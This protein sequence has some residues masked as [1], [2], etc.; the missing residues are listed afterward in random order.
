ML[1]DAHTHTRIRSV[2]NHRLN[3]SSFKTDFLVEYGI[4]ITLQCLPICQSLVPCFA[5]RSTFT[6][7]DIFKSHF[8]RSNHPTTCTHFDR[9][10]TKGKTSLHC[11]IADGRTCIF[12]E[13]TGST[14]G[15]HLGHHIQ[16]YIFCSHPFAQFTV[17][18]DTHC[19][20]SWLKNTLRSQYH[21]HFTCSDAES[22]CSHRTMS[23][24]VRVTADNRHSRQSQTTFGTY[25]MDNSIL[26]MHHTVVCQTKILRILSQ[27]VDLR[28]R[29]RIL[30]LLILI[31]CR[32]VMVGHTKY[33]FRT[34]HSDSTFTQSGKS[35][36][37]SHFMTI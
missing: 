31:V 17:Y 12:Y 13:V 21:F 3:I 2:S 24:S 35:L 5:L 26:R 18:G 20:R 22:D 14:A 23:R 11:Q 19:F 25:H 16:S 6:S 36:R 8:V 1:C 30:N 7:L 27:C 29:N 15:S 28:F 33:L 34:Q 9:K 4:V 37:T 32:C 10:V